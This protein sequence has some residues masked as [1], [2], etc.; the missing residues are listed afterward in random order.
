MNKT[1]IY[2]KKGRLSAIFVWENF[3]HLCLNL[4]FLPCCKRWSD[5]LTPNVFIEIFSWH[6]NGPL[7]ANLFILF[8]FYATLTQTG[9]CQ[10]HWSWPCFF[11][12]CMQLKLA[13]RKFYSIKNSPLATILVPPTGIW[14]KSG[15]CVFA[16]ITEMSEY[17]EYVWY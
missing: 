9:D 3:L 4:M 14:N 13:W 8:F 2:L 17:D 11:K 7:A 1:F 6:Q 12:Y 15:P 16:K 5:R 10:L